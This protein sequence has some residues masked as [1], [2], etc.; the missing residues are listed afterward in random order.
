M[1]FTLPV[2]IRLCATPHTALTG[3]MQLFSGAS[4]PL[5]GAMEEEERDPPGIAG[6]GNE[7]VG[8]PL[9]WA[10]AEHQS[11][12]VVVDQLEATRKH[13]A[14]PVSAKTVFVYLYQGR[15]ASRLPLALIFRAVGALVQLFVP[16]RSVRWC[17]SE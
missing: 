9:S 12:V 15:R 2:H 14:K 13:G 11:V 1:V 10:D 6:Y 8:C 3:V 16:S 5:P 17:R 7:R 4:W